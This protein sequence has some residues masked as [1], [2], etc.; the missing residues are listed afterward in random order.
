[1]ILSEDESSINDIMAG[2]EIFIFEE[3]NGI[4]SNYYNEYLKKH[5]NDRLINI[6]FISNSAVQKTFRISLNTSI[7]E[8]IK[9]YL[10]EMN[11]P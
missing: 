3:L 8:M 6:L 4:D 7:K 11:I 1:M 9:I 10:F 2:T 5:S